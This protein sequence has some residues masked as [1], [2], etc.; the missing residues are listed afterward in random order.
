MPD[1]APTDTTPTDTASADSTPIDTG[2][3]GDPSTGVEPFA[4][5]LPRDTTYAN[6][7]IS[8]TRFVVRT[9]DPSSFLAGL[10]PTPDGPTFGYL[11]VT[12]TNLLTA[13]EVTFADTAYDFVLP[14]GSSVPAT[15]VD[16][17]NTALAGETVTTVL[18]FELPA[19]APLG[20]VPTDLIPDLLR[21]DERC[22]VYVAEES[23]HLAAFA[24]GPRLSLVK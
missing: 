13:T 12:T 19:G 6:L 22:D 20:K 23:G 17:A 4:A 21:V 10:E 16:G 1:T 2:S 9:Q 24:A 15:Y 3:V 5:T 14:D 11:D 8:L 7:A 18:A